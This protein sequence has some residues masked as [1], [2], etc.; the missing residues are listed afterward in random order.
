[1]TKLKGFFLQRKLDPVYKALFDSHLR[2]HDTVWNALSITKLSQLQRIQI[3]ARK[4]IVNDKCKY[5]WGL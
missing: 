3:R 2:Y 4:L 5:G 1:M